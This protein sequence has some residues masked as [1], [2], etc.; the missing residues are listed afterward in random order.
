MAGSACVGCCGFDDV[1]G[2]FRSLRVGLGYT[3]RSRSSAGVCY[4]LSFGVLG[5]LS[6]V[7][8]EVRIRSSQKASTQAYLLF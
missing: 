5:I 4:G 3:I 8:F 2:A 6:L 7:D 1:S